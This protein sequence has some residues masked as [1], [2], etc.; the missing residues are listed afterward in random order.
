MDASAIS[1][2]S[3]S[4][5]RSAVPSGD[6]RLL[7]NVDRFAEILARSPPEAPRSV[8]VGRPDFEGVP[9][10]DEV[11]ALNGAEP[12]RAPAPE[13][14]SGLIPGVEEPDEPEPRVIDPL[15][16]ALS[17]PPVGASHLPGV[18]TPGPDLQ[19]SGWIDPSVA[20]VLR[21]VAW[22]G[23]RRRGAARLELGGSRFGGTSVVVHA[24]GREVT[25]ELDG[26]RHS[27]AAELGA[28]L[29]ERLEKRGLVV[30]ALT[31]REAR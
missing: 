28:R 5:P 9:I 1:L 3:G 8:L 6:P 24:E 17:N 13:R 27:D 16:L 10:R 14:E 29:K 12:R 25:L 7:K 18:G 22:G 23:D 11:L 19:R 20:E 4:S 15:E 26:P 2:R 30:R 21:A 31:F